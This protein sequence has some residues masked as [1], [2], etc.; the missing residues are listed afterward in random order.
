MKILIIGSDSI[1]LSGFTLSLARLEEDISFIS[2]TPCYYQQVKETFVIPFR[3]TSPLW[4]LS[5]YRKLKK[6][7]ITNRP[8]VVHI[9]QVNRLAYF[10][11]RICAKMKIPCV[12]T[13]WGSDVLLVPDKNPFFKYL[14]RKTLER[15]QHV[16]A[17]SS[18]MIDKMKQLVPGSSE[19]YILLQ[20]GID[21]VP[22]GSKEKIIYSNRLH[23]PLYRIDQIIRYFTEFSG[24][25]PDW[26]L[27]IAGE[28]TETEMLKRMVDERRIGERV[29]FLGW[30]GPKENKSWYSRSEVYISIPE[31]DGTAVSLLEAMSAGCLPIVPDLEVSREWIK[32]GKNGLIENQGENPLDRLHE[33]DLVSC[34]KE[35]REL[36]EAKA[37][38][39]VN[40]SRFVQFYQSAIDA[41]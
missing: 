28:G 17:D 7:L 35:N 14:V 29:K 40:T 3:S 32:D 15:S 18:E 6:V 5:S 10:V 2:D 11:S 4:L 22:E 25:N 16:T 24:G 37:D 13:A 12:T 23:K 31:S 34:R 9:H 19:K 30:L 1:H 33:I 21:Q 36:I 41:I 26:K 38:R 39:N 8:D 27:V 20:Y